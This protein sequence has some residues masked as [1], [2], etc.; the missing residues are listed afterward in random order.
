MRVKLSLKDLGKASDALKLYNAY[1]S[2][3]DDNAG[4]LNV[5][6]ALAGL[7]DLGSTNK[8]ENMAK[9]LSKAGIAGEDLRNVLQSMDYD[10][11]KITE[12]MRDLGDTGVRGVDKLKL[13][14]NGLGE[15][16]KG[17]AAKLKAFFSGPGGLIT[18][19]AIA[20][21]AIT[22]V[23][24]HQYQAID[25]AIDK[26][27]ESRSSYNELKSEVESLNE[28]Y[29]KTAARIEYLDNLETPTLAE[30]D[31]LDKL[32]EANALLKTQ[33]E[34]KDNLAKYSRQAAAD[35][36]AN[37]LTTERSYV[38]GGADGVTI[39]PDGFMNY[40][41]GKRN[42]LEE[43]KA[44]YEELESLEKQKHELEK[45]NIGLD[46]E[47]KAYKDNATQIELINR[48]MG[49]LTSDITT[50][51]GAIDSAY[52][53]ITEE[54]VTGYGELIQIVN[55]F[56][57]AIAGTP[58]HVQE[59]ANEMK[60]AF[61]KALSSDD[62]SSGFHADMKSDF[63]EW[64]AGLSEDDFQL[65]Y[66]IYLETGG[67]LTSI[68][69]Y[70]AAM[71]EARGTTEK[72][73]SPTENLQSKL[74]E[75][76]D[77]EGFADSRKELVK[78]SKSLDG[79]DEKDIEALAT[80]GS[81]L[82]EV[83]EE[84]GMNAKFLASILQKV[85]EGEDGLS[86]ITDEML[87]LN[88]ALEGAAGMFDKVTAARQRYNDALSVPEKDDSF[89]TFA[90]AYAKIQEEI[91]AGT[92]N[93]NTFWASAELLFGES[94]LAE[95]GWGDGV[96]SIKSAVAELPGIFGDAESAGTG[97]LDK[98][99][100]MAQVSK[101]VNE[102]GEK[103]VDITK[104][105][106]GSYDFAIDPSNVSKIAKQMN[107]SE[108]AILACIEAM[109]MFGEV[110]YY[111]LEEVVSALD[112]FG[113]TM[114]IAGEKAINLQQ[115][116]AHLRALGWGSKA[117]HDLVEQMK[118][119]D[120]VTLI[121]VNAEAGALVS[122]LQTLGLVTQDGN[123]FKIDYVSLVEFLAQ[124]GFTREQVELLTSTL[125]NFNG[126]EIA[127]IEHKKTIL[128]KTLWKDTEDG[129]YGVLDAAD[130][131]NDSSI[132]N[133]SDQFEEFRKKCVLINKELQKM[134]S[135][136]GVVNSSG[137]PSVQTGGSGGSTGA[138]QGN[139]ST[140]PI[141][142][143]ATGT[144]NSPGGL[145][146]LGDE[147][148][149]TGEPK[150]ELVVSGDEAYL[151]GVDGPVIGNLK[152][153]DRVYTADETKKILRSNRKV[154]GRIPAFEG[155]GTFAGSNIPG[156]T[157]TGTG[158]TSSG[159]GSSSD[160]E[161]EFER[162]YKYHQHLRA[163]EQETDAEYLAWLV[164]A[165]KEAYEKG[166]MELD[167]Y[168]KYT[169]EVYELQKEIFQDHLSDIEHQIE[170]LNR[171]AGNQAAI[172]ALYE[173]MIADIK[174]EIAS[175]KSRGLDENSEYIQ[176]LES[177]LW[178]Y[179]DEISDIQEEISENAKDALDEL[180]DYRIDML[181]EELEAEKDALDSRL[182][183]LQDFYDKQKQMLQDKYDEE[184]YLEEQA[185]KRKSKSDI[186][187][188]L[189]RLRFDDSA[190]AQK[191][192]LEL[193]SELA[194]A[195]KDLD[196]FE[197]D[198][199]LEDALALLD[200][201]QEE[202]TATIEAQIDALDKK[203]NDPKALYN[204]ALSDIQDN[205]ANLY[206]EM[207]EYN[208]KNGSGNAEDVAA[209][210]DEAY[211]SLKEYMD[212]FGKAYMDVALVASSSQ[213]TSDGYASGTFSA[214]PGLKRVNEAG[215][216]DIFVRANGDRYRMFRGGEKVLNAKATEFLYNF[217]TSGG[218]YI[219]ELFADVVGKMRNA[220]LE[221]F[222]TN[223]QVVEIKTGDIIIQGNADERTVSQIRREQR[224][225]ID[226]ILKEFT[227]LN[228]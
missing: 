25:R 199:A 98:M 88:K 121:D 120:G 83:L 124:I 125:E 97:L 123:L 106:D 51:M 192:K 31:E 200:K 26:A 56:Y 174:S 105:A 218:A 46:P 3:L 93:S 148:S 178:D 146:L 173:K 36:S 40:Q 185:E 30:Q 92:T 168:R 141:Q 211:A 169:E 118:G 219:P 76:W 189:A 61:A 15:S 66:E 58:T 187:A 18:L 184:K 217:A 153:G 151:A 117:I 145:A 95:W 37:V 131:V 16:I 19:G 7:K 110:T 75:L 23:A 181:K 2:G 155:G 226:Y 198:H 158:S 167:D 112:N 137:G 135:N 160:A 166:E 49:V 99:Y 142:R 21:T 11:D 196:S 113:I 136:I 45:A 164:S 179:Q 59:A 34:L 29:K 50:N 1:L 186:E 64:L 73:L 207:V 109:S 176:E 170:G 134:A 100:S 8:L 27:E 228:R 128:D 114:D 13:T 86:L 127:N 201:Q 4:G 24:I 180:I 80:E 152:P 6:D 157:A 103:L 140:T 202:Q 53:S 213:I 70:E 216:E 149:P 227:R 122:N 129:L 96:D 191:R 150:P 138:H 193:E 47:S 74:Q 72:L 12:A 182:D 205:T 222:Q 35:D 195:Q 101:L 5:F 159:A 203:L 165:Y 28:E 223:N 162:L 32:E 60:S 81:V 221:N 208:F 194:A 108:E 89:K 17:A 78:L 119:L 212:L 210:W 91:K 62:K 90:D 115:L 177:Q 220:L 130:D 111:N 161:S 147:Y 204:R 154:V 20:L 143:E 163:M 39:G 54:G 139:I 57:K 85:A 33:I 55:E 190:W 183:E 215:P 79:I 116:E 175:A 94:Q 77:A 188:E 10:N 172:I 209:M 69:Q 224:A 206:E 38:V 87:E 41:T 68:A 102:N 82:A 144:S 65:A 67:A 214:T 132:D 52:K 44:Y 63:N 126:L 14:F 71:D 225:G 42:I 22:A 107:I 9:S 171:E 43:T 104:N 197:K 48:K 133:V 84:D 156:S